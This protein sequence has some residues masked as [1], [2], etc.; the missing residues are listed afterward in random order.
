MGLR[1]IKIRREVIDLG[2][3]GS[4]EVRGLSL[5]DIMAVVGEHGAQMSLMFNR[6]MEQRDEGSGF[7]PDDTQKLLTTLGAEF[8]EIVVAAI[9]L[10]ADDY[11]PEGLQS[12]RAITINGQI[13]ALLAI[14]AL[15]FRS[16]GDV[17]KL[18]ESLTRAALKASG[19]LTG[20]G[21]ISL[22]GIGGS[23]GVPAFS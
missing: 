9:A 21:R 13:E 14:F 22:D 6:V 2:D 4:F 18:V 11:T 10:A 16:E 7:T 5:T 12:A 1:D 23:G 17:K 19:A 20:I 8:P 3:D 15:T